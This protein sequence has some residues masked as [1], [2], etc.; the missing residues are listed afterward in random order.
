MV[1]RESKFEHPLPKALRDTIR[2]GKTRDL[3][4]H[5]SWHGRRKTPKHPN[6]PFPNEAR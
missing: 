2:G 4:L 6:P 1:R 3:R 5:L